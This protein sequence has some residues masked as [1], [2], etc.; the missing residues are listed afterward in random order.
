LAVAAV[1]AVVVCVLWHGRVP[2]ALKASALCAGSVIVTPYVL[3]YDMCILSVA[4]AFLVKDELARGFLPRERGA[5]LG[6]WAALFLLPGP[7]P[8]IVCA[9]LLILVL[10]RAARDFD[11]A[12]G[13]S[14]VDHPAAIGVGM[15]EQPI[16]TDWGPRAIPSSRRS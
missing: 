11:G 9:I 6:C 3:G 5:I 16:S 2:Y 7:T 12:I 1:V 10:R 4:V 14:A 8:P 15:G 13:S